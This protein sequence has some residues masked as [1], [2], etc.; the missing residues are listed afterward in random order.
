MDGNGRWAKEK[1][2]PRTFGHRE[3]AEKVKKNLKEAKRLGVKVLTVFAFSTENWSR[4][5]KEREFIFSY[6]EHFLR[7]Y[8]KELMQEDIKLRMLGRRDRIP[9][10]TIKKI[11]EIE[12]LTKNNKS[13]IFNIA[14][15]YGG[16]WDI[17]QAAKSI[18]HDC[19][20]KKISEEQI[21]EKLFKSYLSLKDVPEPDLLIRTSGEERISNFLLWD[22]AYS[23]LYFPEIYWPSF[24]EKELQKAIEIY[25]KRE[26]KFG[27][28]YD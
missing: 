22:L 16:R 3:G 21:D 5:K 11:E 6:L 18:V 28:I 24:N 25:S 10:K 12:E 4:P 17:T 15:D 27:N 23:E 9:P 8:A 14:L 7:T 2:L 1:N 13:F 19:I 20:N 26:R